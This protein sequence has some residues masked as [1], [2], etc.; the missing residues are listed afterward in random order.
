VTRARRDLDHARS[1]IDDLEAVVWETD[2]AGRFTFVSAGA[3]RLLG[4]PR[5]SWLAEGFLDDRIDPDD[6]RATLGAI[7]SSIRERRPFDLE[8]RLRH[9]DGRT[10]W[11]RAL[12]RP[13]TDGDGSRGIVVDVSRHMLEEEL[14]SE[15]ELRY[16]RL[17]EHLPAIVYTQSVNDGGAGVTY[18][19]PQIRSILGIDQE[20]WI[21]ST[22]GWL[23]SVHED[24]RARVEAANAR[25]DESGEPFAAEYRVTTANGTVV[26][27]HDEAALVRDE[28]GRPLFWQGVMLDVT[29]QRRATELE[30]ALATERAAS[31]TLRELDDLKNT[32]LQAVSH[33]LRTPL[34]AIVGLAVTLERDDVELSA[35]EARDFAARIVANARKLDRIVTDLLDLDRI[36][37]GDVHPNLVRTDVGAFVGRV[38]EESDLVADRDVAVDVATAVAEVDPPKVERIVENLLANTARHTPRGTHVWVR[39]RA[40]DDGVEIDVEDDGPGI[41]PDLRE[42]VFEPFNRGNAS[43]ERGAGV[44]IGLALVQRFAQLHGGRAW[45]EER[46]GGGASFRVWLPARHEPE[47][48]E[49]A[50]V[51]PVV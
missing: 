8:F 37:R 43:I 21:G 12:G 17:I 10:V 11:V 6:R 4:V 33:D 19:S 47:P 16:Q 13:R 20:D 3:E 9:D 25:S 14:R 41:A 28:D 24:D 36:G 23:A 50:G 51:A 49:S 39:V 30:A 42:A 34:A 48:A 32:F 22:A 15:L 18:V 7:A 27:F 26:W 38:V 40:E 44:G 46:A 1:L 29:E 5:D 31:D 45:V 35:D 2:R